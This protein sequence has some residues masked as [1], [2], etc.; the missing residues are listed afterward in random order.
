MN[1]IISLAGAAAALTLAASL[2][3]PA[4]AGELGGWGRG[5]IKDDYMAPRSAASPCYFRADVGYSFQTAPTLR[6]SAWNPPEGYN[7]KVR[8]TSMDDTWTGGVG[9]GCGSGSRGFRYEFML[10][11]H[12]QRGIAG[13]TA[14]FQYLGGDPATSRITS[15]ITTYT[16]M[17]NGYYDL[18]NIRGVVPY[19]GLGVGLAYH[20]MD[21][22]LISHP[23]A[24]ANVPYKTHGDSDLTLA[25]SAMAGFAY[26]VSDRAILDFGYRYIDFG[27]AATARHD[28]FAQ[29]SHS[30]L[31]V[32][33]Q[34]AHE[35]KIGLRYHLGNDGCC[36][37]RPIPMK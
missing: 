13:T 19:I 23:S 31:A 2:A 30:R 17:V 20:Q 6:W 27:R 36:A 33:D 28:V 10:G 29:G 12:G 15:A 16:G 3:T 11:Y 37:A 18:G 34:S 14:P 7:E 22:Y 25:W 4:A 26:Q 21:D 24:P 32:D 8:N 5:S 1:K 35:I 9:V